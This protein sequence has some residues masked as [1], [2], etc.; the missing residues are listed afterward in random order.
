LDLKNPEKIIA[1]S[2]K[3]R[4]LLKPTEKYEKEGFINNVVFPTG[5]V[6]TLDGKSLLI[7]SGGADKVVSVKKISFKDIFKNMEKV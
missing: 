2:P 4:P 7:Y 3:K 1:R 6:P 5:A